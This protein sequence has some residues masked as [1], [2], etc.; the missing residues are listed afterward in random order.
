MGIFGRKKTKVAVISD[1]GRFNRII[2]SQEVSASGVA[3]HVTSALRNDPTLA[4][5]HEFR[6]ILTPLS[7]SAGQRIV[8]VG[9]WGANVAELNDRGLWESSVYWRSHGRSNGVTCPVRITWTDRAPDG[10]LSGVVVSLD[11]PRDA[12]VASLGPSNLT[13]EEVQA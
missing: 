6:A 4:D 5:K 12:Q 9:G 1:A 10:Q 7:E 11:V 3:V 2:P 13:I 8:A